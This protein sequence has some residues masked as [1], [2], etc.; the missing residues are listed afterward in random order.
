MKLANSSVD[1]LKALPLRA[2]VAFAARCARRVEHPAELPDGNPQRE[3]RRKAIEAAFRLAE[4]YAKGADSPPDESVVAAMD[5]A[6]D[7]GGEHACSVATS[8][9]AQA[10]RAAV[11]AWHAGPQGAQDSRALSHLTH[12]TAELAALN[13]FTAAAEAFISVGYRN[14]DFVDAALGDYDKLVRLKP[15]RLYRLYGTRT[16][17]TLSVFPGAVMSWCL[18]F[19]R[20]LVRRTRDNS[21][22]MLLNAFGR[23]PRYAWLC[24]ESVEV[25]VPAEELEKGNVVVVHT[26]EVVPVDGRV[27]E[28]LATIDQQTLT[29]KAT[30]AEKGAGDRVFAAMTLLAGKVH[31]A[32][33]RSGTETASAQ[34]SQILAQTA[35]HKLSSQHKGE[36]LA[37]QVVLPTLAAGVVGMATMGPIGAVAVLNSDLGTGIRMAAPLAMLSPTST[38]T[39]I[40]RTAKVIRWS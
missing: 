20:F 38:R 2:I 16:L 13:A 10:A 3:S 9:I 8:A 37:D 34:I 14:E 30:P 23:Q 12:I 40:W 28:G 33:E 11:S 25:Q 4:S 36:R 35:G 1:Q 21:Q 39:L 29:G 18:N 24:K 26:G 31:V 22:K 17:G 32:V 19:G 5:A 6:R 7:A 15:Y 27:V